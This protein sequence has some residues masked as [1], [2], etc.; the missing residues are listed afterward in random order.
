[1]KKILIAILAL[2]YL[3]ASSG[4]AMT[5]HYCMGKVSSID[6]Y[7]NN[8]KC[9]KCGMKK[10][11]GCCKDKIKIIKIDDTHKL[12]S[13][14]INIFAPTAIVNNAQS[15]FNTNLHYQAI[16]SDFNDHSPPVSSGS[17]LCI[18]YCVFRI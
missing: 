12:I 15:C 6:L 16:R 5:V 1:M 7:S 3:A 13:N 8:D 4:I 2:L 9:G 14:S 11:N 17:S 10:S 18:L